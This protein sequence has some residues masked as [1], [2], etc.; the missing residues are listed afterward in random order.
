MIVV[1]FPCAAQ[2]RTEEAAPAVVGR[3]YFGY[4]IDYR[5][6]ESVCHR[7]SSWAGTVTIR[8]STVR[9]ASGA[10]VEPGSDAY[11][12]MGICREE[13]GA[14]VNLRLGIDVGG[15]NTD[16]VVLD[17]A[18]SLLALVSS[19]TTADVMGGVKNA[20]DGLVAEHP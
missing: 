5:P 13:E 9:G 10:R 20:I 4:E 6:I 3:R 11:R 7:C 8:S 15:T 16:A 14:V 17:E 12:A 1:G 18:G 2:W 19:R